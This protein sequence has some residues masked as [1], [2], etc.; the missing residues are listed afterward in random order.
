VVIFTSRPLSLRGEK[1]GVRKEYKIDFGLG[2]ISTFWEREKPPVPIMGQLNA[3]LRVK[4]ASPRV[5]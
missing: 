1:I 3:S 5:E 2:Q 4:Y